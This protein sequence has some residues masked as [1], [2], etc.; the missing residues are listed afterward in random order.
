M[1]RCIKHIFL[2]L[3]FFSTFFIASELHAVDASLGGFKCPTFAIPGQTELA[4]FKISQ[5]DD[6]N[7]TTNQP[8][9]GRFFCVTIPVGINEVN[10]AQ[11]IKGIDKDG[12]FVIDQSWGDEDVRMQ[13]HDNSLCSASGGIPG[14]PGSYLVSG[15]GQWNSYQSDDKR[16]DRAT[17]PLINSVKCGAAEVN[18]RLRFYFNDLDADV[19]DAYVYFFKKADGDEQQVN[20]VPLCAQNNGK[21]KSICE[22]NSQCFWWVAPAKCMAKADPAVDCTQL[23][24]DV[25]ATANYCTTGENNTCIK[26]TTDV[27]M[28]K[29]VDQYIADRYRRPDDY[30]GP[31]PACAF[32]GTCRSV[33]DLIELGVNVA[34]WLFGI[35]AGLGFAFFVY[36]GL[37]MVLSFG[38]SEKVG[39]GKQILV[40]ATVGMIIAFSAYILV[41]FI[42]KAIGINPNLTP[43]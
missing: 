16:P 12:V 2:T 27:D 18:A 43:F 11:L 6:F 32:T 5:D 14:V 28:S 42:V 33:E 41:S 25:C 7:E 40:A 21:E 36:G 19:D 10:W 24:P 8:T 35:I 3:S 31:L 22:A 20:P 17:Y 34:N 23:P 30:T 15:T 9:G 29:A 37:T 4:I 13:I 39:Q 26:K 38:N 1:N